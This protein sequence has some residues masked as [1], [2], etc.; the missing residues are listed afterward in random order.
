MNKEFQSGN[1]SFPS[2]GSSPPFRTNNNNHKSSSI[3]IHNP[4]QSLTFY[5]NYMKNPFTKKD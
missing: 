4:F 3:I 1:Y 5:Y 2:A